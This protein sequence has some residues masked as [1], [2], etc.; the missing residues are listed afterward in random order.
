MC[1]LRHW[2]AVAS[3]NKEHGLLS[4]AATSKIPPPA[5]ITMDILC[6]YNDIPVLAR[7]NN[8]FSATFKLNFNTEPQTE[9]EFKT[10]LPCHGGGKNQF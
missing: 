6:K 9:V 8:L 2:E 5:V 3:N 10:R 4:L 1:L 7:E